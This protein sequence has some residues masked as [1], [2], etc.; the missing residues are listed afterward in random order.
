MIQLIEAPPR[1]GKTFYFVKY[2]SKFWNY[3][4]LYNEFIV[5]SDVL[6][7]SNVEGLKCRHWK[8]PECMKGRSVEEFFTIAN[9]EAIMEKTGKNHIILGLD[10]VHEV[11]PCSMSIKTHP[12][13]YEFFAYHGHIGIDVFL[14]TQGIDAT[15]RIF[16]PL[17]EFVVK[18]KPRSQKLYKLFSYDFY[19]TKGIFLYSKSLKVDAL[20]FQA[21]KSF[22]KDEQNKPKSAL[23]KYALAGVCCIALAVGMFSYGINN[24]ASG[25]NKGKVRETAKAQKLVQT[26]RS[27]EP[28]SEVVEADPQP[29]LESTVQDWSVYYVEGYVEKHGQLSFIINGR[30]MKDS[31]NFRN[32]SPESLTIEF[33]GEEIKPAG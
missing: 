16:I 24:I 18:V 4:A 32:F 19:T 12:T 21:Y 26:P 5:D 22:R 13:I 11:F 9:F 33:Y 29:V 15:S 23:L 7:I 8:F 25:G 14:M 28:V 3:D 10:E 2:L 6:I 20:V 17:L 27:V 30:Y 31:P 1:S